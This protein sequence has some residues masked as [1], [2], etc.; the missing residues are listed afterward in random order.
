M[1]HFSAGKSPS[2][3]FRFYFSFFAD[4]MK[5]RNVKNTPEVIINGDTKRKHKPVS[6][7]IRCIVSESKLIQW[8][9]LSEQ[10]VT[11]CF[12]AFRR[13]IWNGLKKTSPALQPMRKL[14][15]TILQIFAENE[16]DFLQDCVFGTWPWCY[17]GDWGRSG[18]L[19]TSG[20]NS[21]SKGVGSS[22]GQVIPLCSLEKHLIRK[23]CHPFPPPLPPLGV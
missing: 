15:W 11:S 6:S 13:M 2:S 4:G 1:W 23:V 18:G 3:K 21:G 5:M 7:W 10:R 12:F 16:M 20:A 9:W 17:Q 22:L 8:Q 19:V 14:S